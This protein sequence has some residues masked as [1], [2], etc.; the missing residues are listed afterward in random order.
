[1]DTIA[2]SLDVEGA[3][4]EELGWRVNSCLLRLFTMLARPRCFASSVVTPQGYKDGGRPCVQPTSSRT[5]SHHLLASFPTAKK[6]ER[7]RSRSRNRRELLSLH[8]AASPSLLNHGGAGLDRIEGHARA[9]VKHHEL[10][11]YEK[12][13]GPLLGLIVM[14]H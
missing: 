14:S 10:G 7:Q 12:P 3:S 8:G 11:V 5:T 6:K 2:V 1:L 4:C 9:L 13:S